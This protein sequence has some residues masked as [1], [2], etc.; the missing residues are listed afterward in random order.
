MAGRVVAHVAAATGACACLVASLLIAPPA[1]A[2]PSPEP[3]A[4][5]RAETPTVITG[6]LEAP[7]EL[8]VAAQGVSPGRPGGQG[9]F[10]VVFAS[11]GRGGQVVR[12]LQVRVAAPQGTS[13]DKISGE[14][15]RCDIE[16]GR[17][18]AICDLRGA[19]GRD[20]DP[21]KLS[22]T[23]DI[24]PAF[25]ADVARIRAWAR[26]AG[27]APE[28][29][30]W[31]VGDQ[32]S[33]T[34]YPS[35]T[36]RLDTP[37]EAVT[38]FRNGPE[39]SRQ[40][41]LGASIGELQG[42]HAV[43][44]WRQ[45]SGPAVTFLLPRVV[46]GV[47][48]EAQQIVEL[49]RVPSQQRYEFAARLVAQGQ[50]IERRISVTVR[51]DRLLTDVDAATPTE[52]EIAAAT[53]L[54][55]LRGALEVDE[56][57]DLRIEGSLVAPAGSRV[58]LRAVGRDVAR[59]TVSWSVGSRRVGDGATVTVTAPAQVGAFSLVTSRVRLP[60]GVTSLAEHIVMATAPTTT[61]RSRLTSRSSTGFCRTAV[62][63]RQ[64]QAKD[65]RATFDIPMGSTGEQKLT[66]RYERVTI[67]D[68]VFDDRGKCTGEGG[69][70]IT[71]GVLVQSA[72][73]RLANVK[74][75]LSAA[76]LSVSGARATVN[77]TL[78]NE[79]TDNI[80][81]D[82][83]GDL[84]APWSGDT[85]D[86]LVGTATFTPIGDPAV[87]PMQ[88]LLKFPEGWEFPLDS[89]QITFADDLGVRLSQ[90]ARGPANAHGTRGTVA[91]S[92][93]IVDL[94]PEDVRVSVANLSLGETP[95]GG[96]ITASGTGRYNLSDQTFDVSLPIQCEGGW[97][98]R[99]CEIFDGLRFGSAA[100]TWSDEGIAIEAEA[101]V[102]VGE[103]RAYGVSLKGAYR[104][105]DDWNLSVSDAAPWDLGNDVVLRALRGSL[106]QRPSGNAAGLTMSI[107]G[108]LEGLALGTAVTVKRF[109]PTL[110]NA[111][112]EDDSDPTCSLDEIKFFI[113][114]EV[115]ALLPGSE[116]PTTFTARA[117]VNLTTLD[118]T[119]ESGASDME[120]GP[121]ELR[122]TD[123]R[124]VISRGQPTSCVPAGEGATA[125]DTGITVRFSG[126]A[127]IL[128]KNYTLNVQSDDRGLCIWGTGDT[129]D[130]GGGFRAVTPK[131]AFTTFP[132][133][134]VVDGDEKIDA[135]RLIMRGG[136]VFPD[137]VEE[138][139]QIPGRG[140]TFEADISADLYEAHFAISYNAD[141]QL[142]L[143]RGA[144]A[145][146][147][148]GQLG[149]GLDV[150]TGGVS[151]GFDG[152]FLGTGRLELD[153]TDE[154]PASRTPMEVRVGIGYEVGQSLK[155][156]LQ[157]GVPSG[158]VSN[159]F[160]VKG[161][162]IRRLSASAAIDL[163]VGTPSIALN[164]DVTLPDGWGSAV[165]LLPGSAV[166]LA[167]N[168]DASRPCLEFRVGTRDGD[169]VVDFGG[170]GFITGNYFRLVLAPT[171]CELPDGR[172]TQRI[173]A[174]WAFSVQGTLLGSPFEATSL[175]QIDSKGVRVDAV[176]QLPSLDLYGVVAFRSHEGVGGPRVT[177]KVDT[178]RDIFDVSL[179]AAIEI[180]DVK[181]KFGVLA[182][183]KGDIKKARDRFVIDLKGTSRTS[184]GPVR[185]ALDPITIK[186]NIP[187]SGSE[188]ATNQLFIDI[189][190]GLTVTL[191]LE[192][193]GS[194][195][196]KGS[197][198]LQMQDSVVTQLSLK[199]GGEFDAVI[200]RVRGEVAVDLCMGTLS[201]INS[202]GSGSQCTLY[203]RASLASSSPAV[204][205]GVTGT[206]FV[207]FK[208]PKPF[209]KI[210]YDR[211]GVQ[212]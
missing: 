125:D 53:S 135:K 143:Y 156:E 7:P 89:S 159:A 170:G 109:T 37:S 106:V 87:S 173:A 142:S 127:R 85:L 19:V 181:S 203:P 23:L 118:F 40:I 133:G 14:R 48:E 50:V 3:R 43:L 124:I 146:L 90:A 209:A 207:P 205:V 46:E 101:A 61:S 165:G 74:A 123:V 166:A 171:G 154:V 183:V 197:G 2:I 71:G 16:E 119:F 192:A 110:T 10:D 193:F 137:D 180:G 22:A 29:G 81:L 86:A 176:L 102:S 83:A 179:D 163:I 158:S 54:P 148:V 76:G 167:V 26:W 152:Y 208:D 4:T 177:L 202:D 67:D 189:S 201:E 70:D 45:V 116:R 92:I 105:E 98:S 174:G 33:V 151:P 64:G 185:V 73:V 150:R 211:A 75:T 38:A 82:I 20:E 206:E 144:G 39:Q 58:T 212:R 80:G 139:F 195:T 108:T 35:A 172:G 25:A 100:L 9:A 138:R 51:G 210:F 161:L 93:D 8:S 94:E 198:R 60:S 56:R 186:G 15:W 113:D 168:L 96:L 169:P 103:S 66:L 122:L 77:S 78:S 42:Q 160:G 13:L 199:A 79:I 5:A 59:G 153:G 190:T 65:A 134:A 24:E 182:S 91:F 200:Y 30:A 47:A 69:I 32:G 149:I 17:L 62:D 147:T 117:D 145:A 68:G 136:F 97:A 99:S 188:S 107:T 36:L 28:F 132:S 121:E 63:I 21:P 44:T 204:R 126:S 27:E 111:C 175:L 12:D 178:E 157:A 187:L 41:L 141:N 162:T 131:V 95:R 115:A 194:Y 49:T 88:A 104:A 155:L 112:P 140:V 18:S 72:R 129:I 114:A 34:V 84:S 31:V 120:V 57:R 164:A 184:L 6:A 11:T 52:A 130:I 191:D 1:S 55:R 196:V 128:T